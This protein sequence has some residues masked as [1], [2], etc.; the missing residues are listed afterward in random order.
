MSGRISTN[1]GASASGSACASPNTFMPGES[2]IHDDASAFN[3]WR[4]V[5]VVVCRPPPSAADTVPVRASA[6]GTSAFKSVDLPMPDCPISTLRWPASATSS[7]ATDRTAEH[8]T[9]A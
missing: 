5:S 7:A 3:G 6:C 1:A 2:T 8:S 9:T 4:T